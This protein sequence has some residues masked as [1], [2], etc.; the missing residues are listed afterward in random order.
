MQ[1]PTKV[2]RGPTIEVGEQ[3]QE[4]FRLFDRPPGTLDGRSGILVEHAEVE[5]R[6]IEVVDQLSL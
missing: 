6:V 3:R 1:G 4:R 2:T 5:Q